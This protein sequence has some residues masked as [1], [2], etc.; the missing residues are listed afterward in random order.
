MTQKELTV[1]GPEPNIEWFLEE[2]ELLNI[3]D[4]TIEVI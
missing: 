2:L 1:S 3:P 4:V